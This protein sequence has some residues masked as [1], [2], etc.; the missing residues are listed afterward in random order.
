MLKNKVEHKIFI[1]NREIDFFTRENFSERYKKVEI[2][3]LER[4]R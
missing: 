4:W 3:F 1:S 2:L